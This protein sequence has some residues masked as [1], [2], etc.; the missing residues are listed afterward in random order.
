MLV[1]ALGK[2]AL[3]MWNSESNMD[4][5][6][7]EVEAVLGY[8]SQ[9]PAPEG[10]EPTVVA[11]LMRND[12]YETYVH[13][14]RDNSADV[15]E[16]LMTIAQHRAIVA[17]LAGKVPEGFMLVPDDLCV[18]MRNAAEEYIERCFNRDEKP[19]MDGTYRAMICAAPLPPSPKE[20]RL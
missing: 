6:A 14:N 11:H 15:V 16:P 4:N 20:G 1:E 19:T 18:G 2:A 10:V 9:F 17:G 13:L 8:L 7:A 5:E 3:A 12:H